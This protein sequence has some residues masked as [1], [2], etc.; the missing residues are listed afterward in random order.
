MNIQIDNY[1]FLLLSGLTIKGEPELLWLLVSIIFFLIVLIVTW[2]GTRKI[3]QYQNEL[4]E[5]NTMLKEQLNN[6]NNCE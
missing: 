3:N 4:I 5:A 2:I 1:V 6:H